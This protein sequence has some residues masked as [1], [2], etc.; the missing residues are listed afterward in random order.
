MATIQNH[1]PTPL[2]ISQSSQQRPKLRVVLLHGLGGESSI[3]DE[4]REILE[5][6]LPI[7]TVAFD[8]AGQGKSSRF[9]AQKYFTIEGQAELVVRRLADLPKLPTIV[10]GHCYGSLVALALTP[11]LTN[12]RFQILISTGSKLP[13]LHWMSQSRLAPFFTRVSDVAGRIFPAIHIKSR[14]DFTSDLNS[15]QFSAKRLIA[16]VLH[17]SVPTYVQLLW[18]SALFPAGSYLLTTG[19]KT[20]IFQGT[21]DSIFPME[22]LKKIVSDNNNITLQPV[23]DAHHV[24]VLQTARTA[25]Y[26]EILDLCANVLKKL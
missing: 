19:I 14:R 25:V 9:Y 21:N 11:Q 26:Q 4:L 20:Q 12:V 24:L 18:S 6:D 22:S 17:T 8:L 23:V 13:I 16:D 3:W 15:G 5:T 2:F 7:E 1:Q 10:V